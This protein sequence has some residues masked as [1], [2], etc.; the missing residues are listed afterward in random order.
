MKSKLSLFIFRRD[1]RLVDNTALISA[2]DNSELVLPIFIFNDKQLKENPYRGDNSVQFLIESLEDLNEKLKEK[3]SKLYV[4]QGDNLEVIEKLIKELKVNA[5]YFN[6]DY[7]PFSIKRDDKITELATKYNIKVESFHDTLLNEPSKVLKED[8]TPYT[9]FT[10]YYNKARLFYVSPPVENNYKNYF[11]D[12]ISFEN[13]IEVVE[14]ILEK[15]N[16]NLY[17]KG[18]RDEALEILNNLKNLNN[19]KEERDFPHLDSTTGLSAHNKFGTV[20]IREVYYQAKEVIENFE[21]FIRQ[22]YWRDFFTQIA[23]NFPKV[24]GN[25]FQDKYND[26]KWSSIKEKTKEWEAW[27]SGKTGYPIVDAAIRE[28]ITT[29]YMHNRC[30]MI[31]ASFLTKDLHINWLEG[32]KFFANYLVD[33]DP[34]V[35]N[36]SWQWAAST[37]CDAQPYF[38]IFNPWLQQ[39]KFDGECIYI[40]KWVPELRHLSPDAIH[41]LFK[42]RPLNMGD[43]P[44]PIVEHQ[45]AK[46]IALSLFKI[47]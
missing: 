15:K 27:C 5:I 7:T 41:N 22:L 33:Y 39:K 43:Y 20:S 42:Q 18:G 25:A 21:P 19:Y 38:R 26:V 4:F 37:G 14:K 45:E 46:D 29:G 11:T 30:R 40:K 10:P 12:I 31:V 16:E 35:N 3:G 8:K 32:E 2:L 47:R 23:F 17:V 9:V 13:G 28:L 36:G 44:R 6:K 34:A 1:I 24:Y